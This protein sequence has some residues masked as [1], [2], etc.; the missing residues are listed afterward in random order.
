MLLLVIRL[1]LRT[2]DI[3]S[4]KLTDFDWTNRKIRI[5]QTKTREPLELPLLEDVGW[6]VIDYLKNGRPKR[7]K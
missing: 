1:G 7:E 6:A 3:H 4:L 2:S 5:V